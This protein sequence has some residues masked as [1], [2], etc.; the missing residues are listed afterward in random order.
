MAA[1]Q[2]RSPTEP[3]TPTEPKDTNFIASMEDEV[4]RCAEHLE[5]RQSRKGYKTLDRKAN[6]YS[7]GTGARGNASGAALSSAKTLPRSFTAPSEPEERT[8]L[9]P[10]VIPPPAAGR[11]SSPERYKARVFKFSTGMD[12]TYPSRQQQHQVREEPDRSAAGYHKGTSVPPE[13]TPF[14]SAG[15]GSC[16]RDSSV[17]PLQSPLGRMPI[18]AVASHSRKSSHSSSSPP[19]P[20]VPPKRLQSSSSP[21]PPAVPPKRQRSSSPPPAVPP[22]PAG[23]IRSRRAKS[24][25]PTSPSRSHTPHK[26]TVVSSIRRNSL[27]LSP[28]SPPP[29]MDPDLISKLSA[30]EEERGQ[31]K[32]P[33]AEVDMDTFHDKVLKAKSLLSAATDDGGDNSRGMESS[34]DAEDYSKPVREQPAPP[35]LGSAA[36]QVGSGVV[37]KVVVSCNDHH[38]QTKEISRG[39]ESS[40]DVCAEIV[41]GDASPPDT[42]SHD[43]LEEPGSGAGDPE[44]PTRDGDLSVAG[45]HLTSRVELV[46]AGQQEE[47]AELGDE[48]TLVGVGEAEEVEQKVED[49]LLDEISEKTQTGSSISPGGVLSSEGK[50]SSQSQESLEETGESVDGNILV[51]CGMGSDDL[52]DQVFIIPAATTASLGSLSIETHE[53]SEPEVKSVPL[54]SHKVSGKHR[55]QHQRGGVNSKHSS[56]STTEGGE[57]PVS[58]SQQSLGSSVDKPSAAASGPKNVELEGVSESIALLVKGLQ[59]QLREKEQDLARLQ[60]QKER[61]LKDRDEKA[62]K[63]A[64]EAKKIEREKWELLKRA[65]DAAERSLHLRTQLDMKEESLRGVQGELDRT[66][67]ELVSVKSANTSLRALLG[68]LRAAGPSVDVAVQVDMSTASLRRNRSIELAFTQ[69]IGR[70]HV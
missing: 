5:R 39:T 61:E 57:D 25:T 3:L 23:S 33:S 52:A 44:P 8:I 47:K 31:L 17:T 20:A 38:P 24:H 49:G 28:P 48:T 18:G 60:R 64:H 35:S 55:S 19:P 13:A 43:S 67:D 58:P 22:K 41:S 10:R 29:P 65:R 9:S 21:P 56:T 11:R 50:E 32:F 42:T 63:L 68:D 15:S 69:E 53:A 62:K 16:S 45:D 34:V 27:T 59:I 70:A 66:R 40:V 1:V 26:V 54:H 30:E 37:S 36:T 12:G 14:F 51:A 46:E 7:S 4:R 2:Q 6:G